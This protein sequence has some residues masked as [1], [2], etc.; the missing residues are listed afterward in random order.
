MQLF[1]T[2]RDTADALHKAI[3]QATVQATIDPQREQAV[4]DILQAVRERG[5]EAVLDYTHRWDCPTLEHLEV[6][7]SELETAHNRIEPELKQALQIIKQ[8]IQQ[9]H[10]RQRR[11]SWHYTDNAGVLLGQIVRPLN[12]VGIYVP[13]GR[14]IYPS[15]VLMNAVPARVAGVREIILCV[16]PRPDGSLPDSVLFAASEAGVDRVFKVGGAQAIAAM[17]YGTQIIP[18]VDKIVGPGN[19]YVNLAKRLLWGTVGVDLWAGP[20]EVAI[21]ADE[22]ANPDWIAADLMTQLEHGEDSVA[23]LF[24]HSETVVLATLQSIER[25]LP[26]RTRQTIMQES[27]K[28]SIAL[29]TCNLKESLYWANIAAPEH[30]SLMVENPGECLDDVENAGCILL[31][32]WTPQ[33]GGD[34]VAGPC[35]TLPTG[36]AARFESPVNPDTFLKKSSLI[37]FQPES[38][39]ALQS[40]LGALAREEGFDAHA[41]GAEI[42]TSST[43][44]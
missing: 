8:R 23:Y 1:N 35:H 29:V 41:Y 33:S 22:H 2:A 30:L 13:G 20:S 32:R 27:L 17:A 21:V 5:D 25:Q 10:E 24:S 19:L 37:G 6:Q 44:P 7:P 34:Y 36:G 9:F 16:P 28:H 39:K 18:A 31:G 15:S 43:P 38:L 40:P 26:L 11:E 14:A 12:R 4:R 42:R 3:R